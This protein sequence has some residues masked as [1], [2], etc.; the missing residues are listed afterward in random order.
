MLDGDFLFAF[1]PGDGDT[2]FIATD[3]YYGQK[4]SQKLYRILMDNPLKSY[5]VHE[6]SQTYTV[7]STED[8]IG[9][10]TFD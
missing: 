8:F 5:F 3:L 7:W 9:P 10:I 1:Y 6:S 4:Y 2:A